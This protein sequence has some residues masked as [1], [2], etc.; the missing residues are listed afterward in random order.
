M[1]WQVA[2]IMR[3]LDLETAAAMRRDDAALRRE[4]AALAG[5][6]VRQVTAEHLRQ[7]RA[8]RG[9]A[10]HREARAALGLDQDQGAAT[11]EPRRRRDGRPGAA[12]RARST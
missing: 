2:L 12:R 1:R 6:P 7:A 10:W 9:L 8:A 11:P 5:L 3:R 4:A